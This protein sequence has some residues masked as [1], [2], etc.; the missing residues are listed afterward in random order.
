MSDWMKQDDETEE[1][2]SYK[3]ELRQAEQIGDRIK[4]K[5]FNRINLKVFEQRLS[6]FKCLDTFDQECQKVA[7]NAFILFTEYPN[8]SIFRN[9]PMPEQDPYNDDYDNETIG[10]EKYISFVADTKGWLYESLLESIN[11]EF[12]ECGTIEEPTISKQF[13]GNEITATH[14]DFENRLFELLRDLC[15][16]LHEYKTIEK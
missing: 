14:L 10:M 7:W 9:A 3:S 15:S 8:E 11:N 5:L 4:Q 1:T 16:L 12:N 13:D 6:Q 2:E